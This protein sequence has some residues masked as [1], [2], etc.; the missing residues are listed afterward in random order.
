LARVLNLLG[1]ELGSDLLPPRADNRRGYWE[2]RAVLDLNERLLSA[3]GSGWHE[4]GPMPH[5]WH[6]LE[7]VRRIRAELVSLLRA[8]FAGHALWGVKDPRLGRLLPVW[9][10]ALQEV[11]AEPSF[12]ILVRHPLEVV[13]SLEVRNHFPPSKCLLLYLSDLL[14]SIAN[15]AGYRRVFVSFTRLLEDWRQEVERI[16]DRL[17]IRWPR[18]PRTQKREIDA[19]LDPSSRHHRYT[20]A[21]LRDERLYPVWL[22]ELHES[23]QNAARGDDS[24]LVPVFTRALESLRSA[25]ALYSPEI[26]SMQATIARLSTDAETSRRKGP[27]HRIEAL[28][29]RAE[30][31]ERELAKVQGH[32]TSILSSRH[33]RWTRSLRRAWRRLGELLP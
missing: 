29:H 28:E 5:G 13:R 22:A 26:D 14:E 20:S 15:T 11:P 1:V 7:E 12:A 21:D 8:D 32:L 6:T 19:F 23:L 3:A 18:D 25:Q 10:R 17:G 2:H 27:D 4:Y 30:R 16:A 31:A 24:D 9:M 33:Y